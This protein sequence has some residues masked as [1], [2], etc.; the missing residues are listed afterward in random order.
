[1]VGDLIECQYGNH[2]IERSN[3]TT[4]GMKGYYTIC[5]ECKR[6]K[7]NIYRRK[8]K[9]Q[10]NEKKREYNRQWMANK[11]AKEKNNKLNEYNN[12]VYVN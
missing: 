1:M 9:E 10:I 7:L 8:N 12:I 4:S 5:R 2:M 3:F 6:K 11:R